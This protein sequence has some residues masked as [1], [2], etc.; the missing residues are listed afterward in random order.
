MEYSFQLC[1][2]Y[3]VN[4]RD[5]ILKAA[6]KLFVEQGEQ[7][8]SMKWI[9]KEAKCGIGTMYNYFSSKEELINVLYLETK[10][11]LLTS[12]FKNHDS[13]FSVKKQ[14][15]ST[16]LGFMDH[17]I[18][19]PLEAGFL[20]MYSHSPKISDKIN[21]EVNKLLFP[22]FEIYEKGKMEGIIKDIDTLQ[23]IVFNNGA[24]SSSIGINPKL[25]IQDREIIVQL[26]WDAIK[27]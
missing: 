2:I 16:W 27:S 21:E 23:L 13:S 20:Q 6:L 9:A 4:K 10:R 3:N 15:I 7:A 18:A 8:T 22:L 25:G 17:S 12:V 14:F 19:N 11:N 5:N 26:A 24:I 1:Y